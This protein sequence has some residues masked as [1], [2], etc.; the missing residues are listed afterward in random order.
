MSLLLI[1]IGY[2]FVQHF[3]APLDGDMAEN[4]VPASHFKPI[5][6]F[7]L[8]IKAISQKIKYPNPNR[9][10]SHWPLKTYFS[11]APLY[12]QK[13]T[14]PIESVYLSCA[15]IKIF[16]QVCLIL[17]LAIT[18]TGIKN[19]FKTEFILAAALVTPLFQTN[20]YRSYMGIIDPSITYTFF[21]AL[22][23]F[24]L[25]LYLIPIIQQ[26]YHG[27]ESNKPLLIKALWIPLAAVV[28]LSGP[29][30]PG[31]ILVFSL[32]VFLSIIKSIYRQGNTITLNQKNT[33][34]FSNIP[35]CCYYLIPIFLFSV[36]SLYLGRFNS[37]NDMYQIS[38]I[39]LY[40]R[41]PIGIYYQF[42]QKLGFPVLFIILIINT[43]LIR[44][45]YNT[46]EGQKIIAAFKWI[47]IFSVIY[48]FLLPLGG[49]RDYRS[50]VL[51]YDTI[52]PITLSLIFLFGSSSLYLIKNATSKNKYWYIPLIGLI[53]FIYTNSD[54]PGFN[55]ND[56]EKKALKEISES[57]GTNIKLN[58]NCT[59]LSWELIQ[60]P[61]KSQLNGELLKIWK[62]TKEKKLYYH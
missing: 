42:T 56:C 32:L 61:D 40:S 25:I 58:C 51:R 16:I 5:F 31:I 54:K 41:L 48:I 7:P 46:S 52:M 21:Y 12:L 43:T 28:C 19:I 15:I 38:L 35:K 49:Y 34:I 44:K 10:F 59:V 26:L 45:K 62:I 55:K 57:K 4:I 9:F 18:I 30:N 36:Y 29:L 8:G 13:F 53:L 50:N 33:S 1:D 11:W 60:N 24:L 2:S 3:S 17:L 47:G 27:K 22:P 20:G 6:K 14:T 39:E 37:H 23:C